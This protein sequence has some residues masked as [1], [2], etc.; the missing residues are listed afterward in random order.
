MR[1]STGSSIA[2]SSSYRP[3]SRQPEP[4]SRSVTSAGGS[5]CRRQY[6]RPGVGP[7][8]RPEVPVDEVCR[9]LAHLDDQP[10][11]VGRSTDHDVRPQSRSAVQDDVVLHPHVSGHRRQ[12]RGEGSD[13]GLVR[14]RR[15]GRQVDAAADQLEPHLLRH[16]A[17]LL[18][19][20][21][22]HVGLVDPEP[23]GPV[24][25]VGADVDELRCRR[26][27]PCGNR[28][29][30]AR[31]A[32][33]QRFGQPLD[34]LGVLGRR[35]RLDP[36][37]PVDQLV[38]AAVT[39]GQLVE[40]VDGPAGRAPGQQSHGGSSLPRTATN[41]K[42][43]PSGA[44]SPDATATARRARQTATH[45]AHEI[46]AGPRP[47]GRWRRAAG[48]RGAGHDDAADRRGDRLAAARRLRP[49]S[50]SAGRA[51]TGCRPSEST[52]LTRRSPTRFLSVLVRKLLQ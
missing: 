52:L 49:R 11:G 39:A 40:V 27:P 37:R 4:S 15:L 18:D 41:H 30:R 21:S 24:V 38:L 6:A 14:R 47:A 50:V 10:W 13:H 17:H 19:P 44:A 31:S 25:E 36:Q 43:T 9:V 20:P 1:S 45:P 46:G 3:V 16:A 32:V 51:R 26:R 8:D 12:G 42:A 34:H 23:P 35:W 33:A 7:Q 22:V 28:H 2:T 29:A 48:Q 5:S